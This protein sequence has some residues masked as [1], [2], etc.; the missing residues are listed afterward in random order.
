MSSHGP[1]RIGIPTQI[2][3]QPD[4]WMK[5][6]LSIGRKV[7]ISLGSAS[8]TSHLLS[9]HPQLRII[10]HINSTVEGEQLLSQLLR[11]I[12]DRH[13]LFKYGRIPLNLILSSRMWDVRYA[14]FVAD[15]FVY[16]LFLAT[17]RT[18]L[19]YS[20]LQSVCDGSS[21]RRAV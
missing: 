1:Q 4:F 19:H 8:I 15:S 20:T 7:F 21:R 16:R 6:K 3:F 10:L 13:W 2:F 9:V 17:Q 18:N 11:A 12:P 5:L 14:I